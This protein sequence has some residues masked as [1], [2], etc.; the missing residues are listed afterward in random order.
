[1][2]NELRVALSTILSRVKLLRI[3]KKVRVPLNVSQGELGMPR[4]IQVPLFA[5]QVEK[6]LGTAALEVIRTCVFLEQTTEAGWHTRCYR[7]RSSASQLTSQLTAH[8]ELRSR[9]LCEPLLGD[10]LTPNGTSRSFFY[11]LLVLSALSSGSVS[12][13]AESKHRFIFQCYQYRSNLVATKIS[14]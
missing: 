14:L 12:L 5:S 9:K 7:Q 4:K 3:A 2:E 1:M 10:H 6:R 8:R 13:L 11:P